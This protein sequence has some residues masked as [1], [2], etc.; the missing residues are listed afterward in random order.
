MRSRSSLSRRGGLLIAILSPALLGSQFKCAFVSN[1]TIATARIEQ[2]EPIMPRVGDVVLVTGTGDGTPPLQF[3]WDFG[4]GTLAAGVQAAHAYVAPGSYRITFT[5]R[6]VNGNAAR[7][8]ALVDVSSR[9]PSSIL[10]LSK[11][12][13]RQPAWFA[14]LPLE[15]TSAPDYVWAFSDGQ[16]ATGLRPAV[17]FPAAG[18]YAA[19][20]TV[21][22][23][24]GEFAIAQVT[25]HV[26]EA[27]H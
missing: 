20:V 5:V 16:S 27:A 17:I 24:L 22:N 3:A 9:I 25:F 18:M 4:D 14:A 7:D 8:E 11:V 12:V 13:A 10:L 6:D 26:A 21:T 1:P 19:S 2:I 15:G 23:D